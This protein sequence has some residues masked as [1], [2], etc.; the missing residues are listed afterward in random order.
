MGRQP[1]QPPRRSQ[2]ISRTGTARVCICP[3]SSR[4][5]LLVEHFFQHHVLEH[6][7]QN[8]DGHDGHGHGGGHA[9]AVVLERGVDGVQRK[10]GRGVARPA[11][12]HDERDIEA[13][14]RAADAVEHNET[15]HQ[16]DVGQLDAP[17]LVPRIGA[18]D[19]GCLHHLGGNGRQAR[20]KQH[21]V[22]SAEPPGG[23]RR[24]HEID[25]CRNHHIHH[26]VLQ[27]SLQRYLLK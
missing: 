4:R 6:I 9:E 24:Q 7:H 18:V 5:L 14:Q 17:E 23:H 10:G 8:D 21:D 13:L 20:G 19:T 25:N 12:R 15:E 27:K 2:D 22:V 26:V 3:G 11:V 1:R 16:P